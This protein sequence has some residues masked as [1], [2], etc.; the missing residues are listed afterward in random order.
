MRCINCFK[1]IG[2]DSICPSCGYNI[3]EYHCPE[4]CLD[5]G[6][7]IGGRYEIGK[8]IGEGGFGITYAAYDKTLN[9]KCAVMEYFPRGLSS[10]MVRTDIKAFFDTAMDYS[11]GTKHFKQEAAKLAKFDGIRNI[12]NVKKLYQRK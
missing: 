11:N 7:I 3:S 10:R 9:S 6:I 2:S 12:V 1:E 4:A 8:V 5:P